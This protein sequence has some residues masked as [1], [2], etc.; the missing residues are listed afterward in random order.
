MNNY[1]KQVTAWLKAQ[2]LSIESCD[3]NIAFH[4]KQIENLEQ[5]IKAEEAEKQAKIETREVII[6]SLK[7]FQN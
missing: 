1:I 3:I 6:N 5:S 7:K 4:K 2:D